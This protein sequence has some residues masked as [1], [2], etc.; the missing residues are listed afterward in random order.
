MYTNILILDFQLIHPCSLHH[1][2]WS[3]LFVGVD[4][5]DSLIHKVHILDGDH[6]AACL[7]LLIV[8]GMIGIG[9]IHSRLG[10]PTLTATETK[11]LVDVHMAEIAKTNI[12]KDVNIRI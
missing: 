12:T 6:L 3:A 1:V 5:A 2:L 10:V 11:N 9:W 4:W 8:K 7:C